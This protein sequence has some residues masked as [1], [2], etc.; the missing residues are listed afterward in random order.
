M[1]NETSN[2]TATWKK[3]LKWTGIVTGALAATLAVT[4]MLLERRSYDPGFPAIRASRDPAVIARGR[5]LVHGPAH[6][7]GCHG[8]ASH[9]TDFAAGREG[10]LSGGMEFHL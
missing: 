4:V 9:A 2:E 8:A 7:A 6:C 10:P 3:I 1:T 5:H